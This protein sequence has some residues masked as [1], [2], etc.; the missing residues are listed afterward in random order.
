MAD[1]A[2]AGMDEGA[3]RK[4]VSDPIV[5]SAKPES[6]SLPGCLSEDQRKRRRAPGSRARPVPHG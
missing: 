3:L 5:P 2:L 4:L 6:Q 1:E